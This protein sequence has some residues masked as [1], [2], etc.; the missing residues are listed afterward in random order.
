[1]GAAAGWAATAGA[2]GLAT[3]A[4]DGPSR[5]I[6]PATATLRH[7]SLHHDSTPCLLSDYQTLSSAFRKPR[8][9]TSSELT[10]LPSRSGPPDS[11]PRLEDCLVRR[12]NGRSSETVSC[13]Q[14][15]T[16]SGTPLAGQ[17]PMAEHTRLGSSPGAA[18]GG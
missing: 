8:P 9:S 2:S 5:A 13:R 3:A 16:A 11:D 1:M 12:R 6:T 7:E 14:R 10:E 18:C 17:P 15:H 4:A